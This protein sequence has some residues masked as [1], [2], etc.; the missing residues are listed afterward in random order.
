MADKEIGFGL[1]G[2]GLIAP[3]HGKSITAADGCN[4]V[5]V[6]DPDAARANKFASEYNCDA[7]SSLED[8]LSDEAI[9]VVCILTPN[10][11]HHESAIACAKAGKHMLI[12]KPPS[13]SL[14]HTDEMISPA[15]EGGVKLGIVLQCRVRKAITAIT[16]A[17]KTGRF[18][19]LLQ[20]D[21]FMKWYRSTEYY[22]SDS[23]R[24][25]RRSGAGVTIQHAF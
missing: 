15:S 1:L 23:W 10:H 12:E 4:L 13:L 6:A 9:D 2:A 7:R 16:Q 17:I 22:L 8:L 5:A 11:M 14:A 21:A 18:G 19:R 25:S 3:F 24:S 20:A